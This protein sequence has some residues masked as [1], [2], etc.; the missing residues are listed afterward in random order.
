MIIKLYS[1][2]SN[3]E[4]FGSV[5]CYTKDGLMKLVDTGYMFPNGIAVQYGS[6]GEPTNL[7]VAET[8]TKSLWAIPYDKTSGSSVP[9]VVSRKRLFGLCPGLCYVVS[10]CLLIND[11]DS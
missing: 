6:D 5:Y 10:N 4:S 1:I 11:S 3:Q 9:V 8:G 7:I 2:C